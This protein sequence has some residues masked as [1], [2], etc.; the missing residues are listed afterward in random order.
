MANRVADRRQFLRTGVAT[1]VGIGLAGCSQDNSG[2]G[3]KGDKS[4]VR[5]AMVQD[6]GSPLNQYISGMGA[7]KD[8]LHQLV[9]DRLLMPSPFVK[10]PISGLA[11][12]TTKIDPSTYT[13]TI[14]EDVKWQDGEPFTV[15]DV[16]FTFKFYR[17]GPSI[18]FAHHVSEM[19]KVNTIKKV[20]DRKVRFETPFPVPSLIEITFADLPIL[21]KH[22]WANV[23][24]PRKYKELPVGTG[25][26]KLVEYTEGER[27]RFQANENYF[28]GKPIVDE[29][30]IPFISGS[31]QAFTAL[32]A[33]EID[34]TLRPVPPST[35][36]KF[37]QN[38]QIRV[39]QATRLA[40]VSLQLNY[41][42]QPFQ[43][44]GFRFALSR[45]LDLDSVVNIVMLGKATSGSEGYTHPRSPWTAQDVNIPHKPK[46][47]RQQLDELGFRDRNGDGVRETPDGENLSFTIKV[48]SNQPQFIRAGE[49]V[50]NQ[51][52][53]FGINSKVRTLDPG[54]LSAQGIWGS[55]KFDML[56]DRFNF[57]LTSDPDQYVLNH[58]SNKFLWNTK[59]FPY[60]EYKT[61]EEQY[62]QANTL[63]KQK[64][65]FHEM[66]RLYNKQPTVIPIWYPKEYQAFRKAAHDAWAEAPPF[67]IHH[68]FSFLPK[69]ARGTA[70][71]KSF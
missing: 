25:P 22:I 2:N 57:H 64:S 8:W 49:L 44:H 68:K 32:Q 26:Y 27:L 17:D 54:T 70:V 46:A 42:R 65:A 71:T 55:Q 11:T 24:N 53:D 16:V 1:A 50:S 33:G 59:E 18:R 41:T 4:T 3:N 19:P 39:V 56:I 14:R 48:P 51:L 6:P 13:A 30:V 47:A 69:D 35:I 7:D 15:E 52:S 28:L 38:D 21:P 29:L 9:F 31:S 36:N 5:F 66:N 34:S 12:E 40:M 23:E 20:G 10:N 60:P 61:L 43:Q 58:G 67:G 62:I 45:A 37:K 63:E